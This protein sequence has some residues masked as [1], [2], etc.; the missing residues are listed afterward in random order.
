[1]WSFDPAVSRVRT[2]SPYTA[3]AVIGLGGLF[4]G[5]TGPLLSTF[6][7]PLVRGA[8]GEHRTAIGLAVNLPQYR[9]NNTYQIQDTFSFSE[10][11][12]GT[13]AVDKKIVVSTSG[14]TG[15]LVGWLSASRSPG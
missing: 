9:F 3:C 5:V 12:G 15:D 4:A 10:A 8:L 2:R 6:V 13:P 14:G 7:P 1:M 11:A